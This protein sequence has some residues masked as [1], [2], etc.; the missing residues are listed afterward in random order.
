MILEIR[1]YR[2]K[3]GTGRMFVR[4]MREECVPLLARFGIRVVGCGASVVA[5]DGREEAFLI[6]AFPSLHDH[7]V[8]EEQF[9]ASEEW[10]CG[11]RDAILSRL[12]DYHSVVFEVSEEAVLQLEAALSSTGPPQAGR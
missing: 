11:P 10:R 7:S 5:E 8:Q 9:Y 6:R 1:T 2:L 3:P 12:I 4:V